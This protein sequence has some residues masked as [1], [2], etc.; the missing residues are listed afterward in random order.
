[1]KHEADEK[2][3]HSNNTTTYITGTLENFV[4]LVG[5]ISTN[6]PSVT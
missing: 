3:Q 4:G 5:I 2:K 1:M 6:S